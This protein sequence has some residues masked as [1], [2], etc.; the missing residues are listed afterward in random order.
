MALYRPELWWH[1]QKESSEKYQKLVNRQGR[2]V[3][4]MFQTT[5]RVSVVRYAGLRPAVS[6]LNKRQRRYRQRILA[7]QRSQT[8]RDILPVTLPEGEKQAQSVELTEVDDHWFKPTRRRKETLRQLRARVITEGTGIDTTTGIEHTEWVEPETFPGNVTPF[9]GD[10]DG[11]AM[12]SRKYTDRPGEISFWMD[13]YR[14]DTG[15]M[16]SRVVWPLLEDVEDLPR[17]QQ[18]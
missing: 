15:W 3:T 4:G 13:G 5:P 8:T 14:L 9:A 17:H 10:K 1:G 16:G 18:G 2:A 11:G 12:A 6:L 7:A